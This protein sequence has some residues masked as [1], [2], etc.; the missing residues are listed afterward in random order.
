MEHYSPVSGG[1]IATVTVNVCGELQFLRHRVDVIGPDCCEPVYSD[2]TLHTIRSGESHPLIESVLHF[3]ARFRGWEAPNEGRFYDKTMAIL[4]ILRPDVVV[5][6]N[7]LRRV[8]QV[9]RAVPTAQIVSWMH[10]ECRLRNWASGQWEEADAFLCCSDYI[11]N[12]LLR[13]YHLDESRVYTALAGVDCGRFYPG[14]DPN[15]GRNLRVLFTGRLDRNKGVDLAVDVVAKLRGRG[16]PIQLSVAGNSWFY[17]RSQRERNPFQVGL[18]RAMKES[19]CDWL[20]HVPRRFL[21]DVMRGHDVALVLSRSQEPFGLVVLESMA[22]G[23]AV[24]A[25]HRGGLTEACGGAAML[26]DPDDLHRV[27]DLLESL[28]KDPAELALWRDRSLQRT[29]TARW[30]HTAEV[31]CRAVGALQE[32]KEAIECRELP[33]AGRSF[34]QTHGPNPRARPK[35]VRLC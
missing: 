33:L 26:V 19:G 22:S 7:D 2:G 17:R 11:R 27:S 3:E 29:R 18:Q 15:H 14:S 23:L 31:L 13:Q 1:A 4:E 9:R 32:S 21:P 10:N 25:S 28:A 5:L 20:G 24:I 30:R 34:V 16:V 6:A 12:W 8:A 35:D